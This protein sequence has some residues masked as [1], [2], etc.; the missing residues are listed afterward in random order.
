MKHLFLTCLAILIISASSFTNAAEVVVYTALDQIYSEPLLK[1]FEQ[2]TG[3]RVL[4]VYDTEANKTVG[5]VNRLIAEQARPRC[6]VFWNNEIAGTV[7]LKQKGI[8]APYASPTAE[9]ISSTYK[10]PGHFWVGFAARAR[11]IIVNTDLVS[12]YHRPETIWDLADQRWRGRTA[13]A[14]PL[15]GT[16]ATHAAALFAQLGSKAAKDYFLALKENQVVVAA[17]NATVRDMVA[18][19][20]VAFGLT[21]TDDANGAIEDGKPVE[22][23]VPDQDEGGLGVLVLPNTVSLIAGAPHENEGQRLIDFLLSPQTEEYLAHCR[24]AQIPLRPGVRTPD[25]VLKI[26][27]LKVLDVPYSEIASAFPESRKFIHEEF[28]P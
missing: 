3:I 12:S 14:N 19:G 27:N 7:V 22:I 11:I 17:G 25:K 28:L 26:S 6:D 18:R 1:R 4:P 8:L 20:E 10:D 24:S 16:T 15:F 21:D 2:S 9:G 5:L 13:I 23:V